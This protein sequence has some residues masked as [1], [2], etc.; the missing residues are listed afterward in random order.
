M[1]FFVYTRIYFVYVGECF[2]ALLCWSPENQGCCLGVEKSRL[3]SFWILLPRSDRLNAGSGLVFGFRTWGM[4]CLVSS[5]FIW[6]EG[7]VYSVRKR[8]R[9]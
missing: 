2:C 7:S 1:G 5:S 3:K 9:T 6:L 4:L 8:L